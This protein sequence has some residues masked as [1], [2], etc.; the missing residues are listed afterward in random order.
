[1]PGM[2]HLP[3]TFSWP[4]CKV[5]DHFVAGGAEMKGSEAAGPES[6]SRQPIEPPTKGMIQ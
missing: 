4:L 1:M 6:T 5:E 2:A 3:C